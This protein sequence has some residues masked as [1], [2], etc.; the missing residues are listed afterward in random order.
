MSRDVAVVQVGLDNGRVVN[1]EIAEHNQKT[2]EA[3]GYTALAAFFEG[4]RRPELS[5]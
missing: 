4:L 1:K 5:G 3:E 2:L